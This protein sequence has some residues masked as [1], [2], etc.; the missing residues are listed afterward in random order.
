[1]VQL[2]TITV[3]SS[4]NI[5]KISTEKLSKAPTYDDTGTY[6]DDV[7]KFPDLRPL[8]QQWLNLTV[9]DRG[10]AVHHRTCHLLVNIRWYHVLLLDNTETCAST[11]SEL[12]HAVPVCSISSDP[13]WLNYGM[14]TLNTRPP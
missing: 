5:P 1:M 10:P 9:L 6:I 13:Q 11:T 2:T 12:L 4:S 8:N 3:N 14:G 7:L